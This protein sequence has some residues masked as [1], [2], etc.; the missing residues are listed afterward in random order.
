MPSMTFFTIP[1]HGHVFTGCVQS[2]IMD[3]NCIAT[4]IIPASPY[5]L[6][7]APFRTVKINRLSLLM[8]DLS[9]KT[10][11]I[12]GLKNPELVEAFPASDQHFFHLPHSLF[13]PFHGKLKIKDLFTLSDVNSYPAF[14]NSLNSCQ[15]T[16]ILFYSKI[17]L[18]SKI[19]ST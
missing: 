7:V 4:P 19:G 8:N 9:S 1:N 16:G 3:T 2:A 6:D 15:R 5:K 14:F 11:S 18:I 10:P 13:Y 12:D 17:D